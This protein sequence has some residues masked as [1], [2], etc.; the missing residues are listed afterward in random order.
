MFESNELFIP[1]TSCRFLS[2]GRGWKEAPVLCR[3]EHNRAGKCATCGFNPVVKLRR[4]AKQ[5]GAEEAYR[6]IEYS[7][8]LT[9][10]Y[11]AQ[12]EKGGISNDSEGIS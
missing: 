10:Q 6:A 5:F 11:R 4:L 7:E 8:E 12:T 2:S 3:R 9:A 1:D